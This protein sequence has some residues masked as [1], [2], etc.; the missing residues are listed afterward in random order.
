MN[1]F[2]DRLSKIEALN[3]NNQFKHQIG[4]ITRK[5]AKVIDIQ[6][7]HFEEFIFNGNL[8]SNKIENEKFT[9]FLSSYDNIYFKI[10]EELFDKLHQDDY[11]FLDEF[12]LEENNYSDLSANAKRLKRIIMEVNNIKNVPEINEMIPVQYLKKKEKRY[13]GIRLFVN[14]REDGYIELYLIDLYHLG[15]NAFNASTGNYDLDRN[16]N[17]TKNYSKCISKLADKFIANEQD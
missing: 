6:K 3:Q 16:Y 8:H 15:I 12:E 11:D 1:I 10:L 5:G 9:N 4:K 17:S 2:Q 13:R 7:F 14:V